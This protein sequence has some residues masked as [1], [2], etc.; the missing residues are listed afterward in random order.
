MLHYLRR[1]S[2]GLV[3]AAAALMPLVATTPA[4]AEIKPFP[5]SF[6]AQQMPVTGGTQ[7]ASGVK[8]RPCCCCTVSETPETCGRR[9]PRSWSR[10]T[11]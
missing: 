1:I 6:H 2:F 11:R 7:Y 3:V 5:A 8:G 9:W 10:T 4:A